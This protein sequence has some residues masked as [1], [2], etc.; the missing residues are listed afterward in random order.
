M[1]DLIDFINHSSHRYVRKLRDF[2]KV[3]SVSA[4]NLGIEDC[5]DALKQS[6]ADVGFA[7]SEAKGKGNPAVIGR[8]EG[9]SRESVLGFYNHYDVQPPD[10]IELWESPPFQPSIRNGRIYARGVFDNKGSLIARLCAID[11]VRNV[12]GEVPVSLTL[13]CEG[14]E[15]IGSPNL[16]EIVKKNRPLLKADAFLWEGGGVDEGDRPILSLGFKGILTVEL[17]AKGPSRDAHSYWAPLLP[18]PAWKLIWALASIKGKDEKVKI[19]GWYD[20]VKE[21]SETET[22]LLQEIEFDEKA[23]KSRF[24]IEDF[25]GQVTGI[26]SRKALLY[27]PTC[28]VC[29]LSSGYRGPGVKTVLPSIAKAKL[30]FRLVEAQKPDSQFSLLQSHLKSKGFGDVQITKVGGCEASKTPPEDPFV[31]FVFR[32]LNDVYGSTPVVLPVMAGTSPMYV[33]RNWLRIPAVSAGG[34]GHPESNLH[35]PNEN[36]RIHDFVRSIKFYAALITSRADFLESV[37]HDKPI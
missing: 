32:K 31:N 35:S 34:V 15:E 8:M 37:G 24:G 21:I 19:D 26:D 5:V 1:K 3:P 28:N 4:Q 17:K 6:M 7:L 2:C 12:L 33:L 10:P 29:G 16:P 9:K 13:L 23:E 11:A 36:I 18:N 14:E 20:D 25:V 30:D 27:N 22:T